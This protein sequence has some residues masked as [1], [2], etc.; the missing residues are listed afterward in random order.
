MRLVKGFDHDKYDIGVSIESPEDTYTQA[1]TSLTGATL[2]TTNPGT[3]GGGSTLNSSATYST[4]YAPDV[5]VKASADPGFGHY[6]VFGVARFLHD[7]VEYVGSGTSKTKLAGGGGAGMTMPLLPK[8]VDFRLSGLIGDGIGRY[9]S[10][11]LNDATVARDGSPQPLPEVI[12][13]AGLTLHATKAVD[14]Y[15]LIGTETILHRES[16]SVVNGKTTTNYGYGNPNYV[17]TGCNIELSTAT[18]TANTRSIVQGVAGFW[19]KALKGDFGTMQTGLEYSYTRKYV[20]RGVG[21]SPSTDE[22]MLFAS[23]RYYPFQ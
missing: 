8:R 21:G 16:Y 23:L 14:L 15:G 22:N 13:L 10:A 18:C 9:G 12:A 19:W 4:E 2:N 6:E 5:I 11:Q 7:R 20:F 3:N 1:A 17:N